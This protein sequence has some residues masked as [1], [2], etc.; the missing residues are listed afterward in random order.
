MRVAL[1][2]P[3]LAPSVDFYRAIAGCDY[4]VYDTSLPY[5]KR[6]K[7]MHRF[8]VA[9]GQTV[10]IPVASHSANPA[11]RTWGSRLV[12]DHGQWPRVLA[13]TMHTLYDTAPY[14][15]DYWPRFEAILGPSAVGR[16]VLDLSLAVDA[17][18]RDI[19][20]IRAKASASLPRNL[21]VGA[22][23]L[24]LRAENF[25]GPSILAEIFLKGPVF[26]D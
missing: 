16:S 20:G 5:D 7:A 12:S 21:P 14:F 15:A 13:S 25:P 1:V 24:D 6:R 3:L 22:E 4:V 11:D 23:I 18:V 9:E 8:S 2:A 17:A 19:L 10:T 26:R